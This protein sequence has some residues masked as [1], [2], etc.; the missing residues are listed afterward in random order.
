MTSERQAQALDLLA[1]SFTP[2]RP[3]DLPEFFA[4]RLSLLYR[5]Q[6]AAN[7]EGLHI[8]LFG[9]RGTG[10]TSISH[11]LA[12]MLQEPSR[13][14]GR[15]AILVSCNSS[16]DYTS[17]WRKVFQEVLLAQR[18]MGFAQHTVST[19]IGRVD[20]G[21]DV[22][23][24]NDVRLFLQS[25][26]NSSVVII[27]E[28]D[29]VSMTNDARRLMADTIKLFSDTNT[30]STL[31]I[32]G[33][34]DSIEELFSE[35]Q[36]ISRNVAQIQVAPMTRDELMEIVRKGFARV[37]MN[38]EEGLDERIAEL[39]QGYPHY[40]HLLGLWA[41]RRGV[42]ADRDTVT[43]LDLNSAIPEALENAAGG[44]QQEYERA[45]SSSRKN[46]LY[47]DVLLA[48]AMAPK[49]SLGR[50]SAVD[51][52]PSLRR[53]TGHDYNTGAFQSHL[54]KFCEHERGPVLKKSGNRRNYK[55]QFVNP[56]LI[57]FIRLRGI[58]DQRITE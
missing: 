53:I 28:F 51:V 32:V 49:D 56:Q 8:I 43:S 14:D 7:T 44:V 35:H 11:V 10:K 33:V 40:T 12:Y 2:H 15:R 1:K 38:F 47:E 16:D 23:D 34:A 37:G 17:I 25:L 3:I 27:D 6:D 42:E 58:R 57:P 13:P 19:V 4:G 21:N 29:R 5:A 36:S 45:I 22:R 30:K 55:W 48:C 54:A 24:P 52:R 41:G 9:D 20:L 39:S 18:Q 31:V 26:S 46:T 50:F